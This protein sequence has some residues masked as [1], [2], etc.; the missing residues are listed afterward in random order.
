MNE[1]FAEWL[2]KREVGK[3]IAEVK[4]RTEGFEFVLSRVQ[5][6]FLIEYF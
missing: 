4:E 6:L 3:R 5:G 2:C 1:A